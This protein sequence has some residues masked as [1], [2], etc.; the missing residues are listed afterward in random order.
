MS[1]E[2]KHYKVL[3]LPKKLNPNVVYYV[4][5]Q[6]TG[7]VKAYISDKT[8]VPIP[9]LDLVSTTSDGKETTLLT[10]EF[11]YTGGPQIFILFHKYY[12]V[13]SVEVQG[14]GSLSKSQY[15][16]LSPN[17]VEILDTLDVDDYITVTY[18][19]VEITNLTPYYTQSQIDVM[20]EE[21]S[22]GTPK[23]GSGY[24]PGGW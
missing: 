6:K 16:L 8:G 7:K 15:K 10:Q 3:E 18:G 24:F 2:I 13:Y 9:L 17:R 11:T 19:T 23:I 20:F 14:Q 1:F 22:G 4:L 5:D 21:F 12:K